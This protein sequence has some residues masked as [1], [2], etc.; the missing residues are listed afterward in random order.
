MKTR[1]YLEVIGYVSGEP[2][3]ETSK[4][5]TAYFKFSVR[6]YENR[7]DSDKTMFMDCIAFGSVAEYM[8]QKVKRGEPVFVSG[9]LINDRWT[10]DQG[11]NRDSWSLKVREY[12]YLSTRL[13][14]QSTESTPAQSQT[15]SQWGDSWGDQKHTSTNWSQNNDR[16]NDPF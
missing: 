1:G 9:E 7:K 16:R 6:W 12:V 4:N 3:L 11:R 10:D 8:S 14:E 15:K 13:S 2:K 5:G